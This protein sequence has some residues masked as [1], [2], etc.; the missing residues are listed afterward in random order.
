[1]SLFRWKKQVQ[2]PKQRRDDHGGRAA[3]SL[4][5]GLNQRLHP[6]IQG[7]PSLESPDKVAQV[8]APQEFGIPFC[9][10]GAQ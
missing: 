1:M 9:E 4:G 3:G 7:D 2:L 10:M 8:P 6:N 5:F